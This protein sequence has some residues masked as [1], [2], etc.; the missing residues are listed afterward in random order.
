MMVP[1]QLMLEIAAVLKKIEAELATVRAEDN[2][3][4]AELRNRWSQVGGCTR[5]GEP[6]DRFAWCLKCRK[7]MSDWRRRKQRK[8]KVA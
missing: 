5:C 1:L 4:K 8:Q 3:R 7:H 6:T 2:Q